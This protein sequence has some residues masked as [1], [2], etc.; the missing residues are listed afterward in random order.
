M[1]KNILL[2]PNGR[3]QQDLLEKLNKNN[4][5]L[6]AVHPNSEYML[7][8]NLIDYL[9]A[10]VREVNKIINFCIKNNIQYLISDQSD[11]ALPSMAKIGHQLHIFNI[12]LEVVDLFT[13]KYLMRKF[14][15]TSFC[16]HLPNF[17][18]ANSYSKLIN[19]IEQ[20]NKVVIKP[21]I[22]QGSQ[23]VLIL[24]NN[25]R[26][27]IDKFINYDF[28]SNSLIV[29]EYLGGVEV[30]VEGYMFSD[31]HLSLCHSVK[32]KFS[33]I[34]TVA[35]SLIFGDQLKIPYQN[36]YQINDDIIDSMHLEYGITH[37]EYKY[38][39]GNF[40]L[41]EVASRGGGNNISSRIVPKLTS[42]DVQKL[43]IQST[44]GIPLMSKDFQPENNCFIELYFFE[45]EYGKVFEK[46]NN[47]NII[48]SDSNLL[49]FNVNL[50]SGQLVN[51]VTSDNDRHGYFIIF[52]DSIDQLRQV[53]ENLVNKMEIVYED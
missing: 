51:R 8:K 37:S 26:N 18:E 22:G 15:T 5:N 41:I 33:Y 9:V 4:F 17:A 42:V 25:N 11:I 45:M 14:L 23:N 24:D 21:R 34:E 43:L 32:E 12:P 20:N 47:L 28:T 16:K 52:S 39:D 19:F 29:E 53:R 44:L 31:G 1:L 30:T 50:S 27:L 36:L 48:H 7:N 40:Y 46:I 3:W 2:L 6:Y 38:I 10:D 35:K 49:D 13:D